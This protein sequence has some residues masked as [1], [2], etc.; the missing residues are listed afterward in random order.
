MSLLGGPISIGRS[1]LGARALRR[2]GLL[3][4]SDPVLTI[5]VVLLLGIGTLLVWSATR[6]WFAAAG[7]DPNA[8]LKQHLVN[9]ALGVI[10]GVGAALIDYRLLRAYTPILWGA[11]VIGLLLVLSPLGAVVNGARAWI[12]LPGGLQ[13]QPAEFAKVA[14]IVGMA[15]I[16][17]E[18]RDGESDPRDLDVFQALLVAG[19][20]VL[21]IVLQPDAGTIAIIAGS[22]L[23]IIAVAG[24]RSRWLVGL[25]SAALVGGYLFVKLDIIEAYQ[26][27][28]LKSFVDPTADPLGSGYQLR[29]SRITIGSGGLFGK[30]LFNGPQ[31]NGRFIPAQQT[32]FIFTVAGE[33]LGFIGSAAI[34]ILLGIVIWRA[35]RI[36]RMSNNLFGR[37]VA[38]GVMAW[39]AFQ[40]FENI[41]MSMGLMPMTGVPL[42]FLSYGGSS[43]FATLIAIGLLQNVHAR[44]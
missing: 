16:L 1:R 30:G 4:R 44:R 19:V 12:I 2:D 29:Q 43:M 21:L 33:E 34:I 40:T 36:A 22:V 13:L 26:L 14:I 5:S 23:T 31:T 17:A 18:K 6:Q 32:D 39:L 27:D 35:A 42:P 38:V 8:Y 11:A 25:I 15:M 3:R 7:L 24:A 37:L 20:P 41:G 9:I 10:L 28:R